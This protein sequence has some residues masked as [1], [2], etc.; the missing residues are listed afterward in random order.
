MVEFEPDQHYSKS[1]EQSVLGV[2][3]LEPAAFRRTKLKPEMFYFEQH[4]VVYKAMAD[5]TAEAIPI[6]LL[7]GFDWLYRRKLIPY[8]AQWETAA[9]LT[10]LT[11]Q[12]VHGA[13]LQVWCETIHDMWKARTLARL[14]PQNVH[15][16]ANQVTAPVK[17]GL[18]I[19]TYRFLLD[20]V[21]KKLIR[22]S[23]PKYG[24]K[25]I[26]G[27]SSHKIR[28]SSPLLVFLM[29]ICE[30]EFTWTCGNL[31]DEELTNDQV[32][33]RIPEN[34]RLDNQRVWIDKTHQFPVSWR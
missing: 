16:I 14:T 2:C 5:M 24:A 27:R 32:K 25:V 10:R 9:F 18:S 11:G 21:E 20:K 1:F 15:L 30:P 34:A 22:K 7:T 23:L 12:V 3:L 4:Q 33:A 8:I 6:D 29:S 28:V 17:T 26:A 13:H 19:R 31:F